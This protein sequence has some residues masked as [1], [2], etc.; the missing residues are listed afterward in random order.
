VQLLPYITESNPNYHNCSKEQI[1]GRTDG[2]TAGRTEKERKKQ[3]NNISEAS[4]K[5][6]NLN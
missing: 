1:D 5:F 3:A 4:Q 2:R 6:I